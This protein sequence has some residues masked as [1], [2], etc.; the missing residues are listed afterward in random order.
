MVLEMT[1]SD[2]GTA[3]ERHMTIQ[4]PRQINSIN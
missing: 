4:A 2:G 3:S 1:T